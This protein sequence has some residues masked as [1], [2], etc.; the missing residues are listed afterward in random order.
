MSTWISGPNSVELL[1]SIALAKFSVMISS[2][3]ARCPTLSALLSCP[4]FAS[5][6]QG[7]Q[8]MDAILQY[9]MYTALIDTFAIPGAQ[10]ISALVD[11]INQSKAKFSVR[12]TLTAVESAFLDE[13]LTGPY[14][15]R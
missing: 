11:M 5:G 10:N 8:A 13:E 4:S 2:K 3:C 7:P 14:R 6:Y 12:P 1:V 9:P 15:P